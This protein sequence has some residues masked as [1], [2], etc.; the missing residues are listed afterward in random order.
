MLWLILIVPAVVTVLLYA[1]LKDKMEW[2]F[3]P[4]PMVASMVIVYGGKDITEYSMC[5]DTEFWSGFVVKAEY[6]ERWNELHEWDTTDTDSK[7]RTTTTHHSEVIDHP[8]VWDIIDSNGILVYISPQEFENLAAEF[9]QRQFVWLGHGYTIHGNKFEAYWP[10]TEET[11]K[12]VTTSHT[13]QN[14]IQCSDTVFKFKKVKP[15]EKKLWGLHDYPP[16]QGYTQRSILGIE[17]AVAERKLSLLNAKL[18]RSK[19]IKV[20]ILVHKN[21]PLDAALAQMNYWEGGNKNE[22]VLN[23][24][25]DDENEV[26]WGYVF[27]WTEA[28]IFK[29]RVR[30]LITDQK[31]LNLGEIVDKLY[32]LVEA[33]WQRKHF[34]DFNYLQV[35]TP[36]WMAL[37]LFFVTVAA[38][39]GFVVFVV[40]KR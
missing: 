6:F 30:D 1:Y 4:I 26:M 3:Y 29:V 33:E 22:L 28:E 12:P 38:N 17:D 35:Q 36:W 5:A 16:I 21:Q 19:Q 10:K 15:D 2:W 7:G 13:Y 9:K 20:F 14:R 18:G 37:V 34:K 27:S 25:V 11:I 32:P 23:I 24:G 8:A 39:I 40:N 31:K